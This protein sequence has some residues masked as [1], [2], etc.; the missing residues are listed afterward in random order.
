[1]G[2]GLTGSGRRP[3]KSPGISDRVEFL[4]RM[5]KLSIPAPHNVEEEDAHEVEGDGDFTEIES[6]RSSGRL[7][8]AFFLARRM[9]TEGHE[10]AADLV[11]RILG[12]MEDG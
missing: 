4:D 12:E 7:P 5:R 11:E 10:D 3:W 2:E 1:M 6:L 8:E 9:A